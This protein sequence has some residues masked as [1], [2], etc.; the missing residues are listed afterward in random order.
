MPVPA[1]TLV[2]R[3]GEREQLLADVQREGMRVVIARGGEGGRGNARFATATRRAPRI[4][5]RGLP[6]ETV[7]LR[8][9][10]RLLA[11][12]GLVGLPNAGKTSLLRAMTRARPKVGTYAFTTLEPNLGVVEAG[13]ERFVVADIP[14][15]MA[16]AHAGAGLGTRFL[17]HVRRTRVLVYVVD[18]S[19]PDPWRDIDVVR[20]ELREFGHGL[21]EKRWLLV[22]NKID[23]PDVRQRLEELRERLA[24]K[25]AEVLPVS[26]LKREGIP[27][28][29][30]RLAAVVQEQRAVAEEE[31]GVEETAVL[32]P[33]AEESVA[34]ER[35][36][37][38]YRVTGEK[39][40]RAVAKLGAESAEAQAEVWRRLRRMGVVS[41]LRR[42]GA[43]P[44]DRVR[45]GEVELEWPG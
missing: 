14:G 23:L 10:L 4:A 26:A 40:A 44:G 43:R 35:V 39:P 22:L 13:Y 8:L 37:E 6:G 9:E 11:E 19:S 33:A 12:V 5:E 45:V 41:R 7:K 15:L 36:G 34:V 16:G 2:W 17:Q 21:A 1:W 42:A 31:A 28:V 29:V 3:V 20:S 32:R 25:G 30:G 38:V 27:D 18:G 24:A